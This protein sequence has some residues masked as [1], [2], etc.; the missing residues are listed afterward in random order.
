ME[1]NVCYSESTLALPP[2]AQ[3]IQCDL[4]PGIKFWP[5]HQTLDQFFVNLHV[6]PASTKTNTLTSN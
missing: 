2:P 6:Y 4:S 5:W 1:K 3:S